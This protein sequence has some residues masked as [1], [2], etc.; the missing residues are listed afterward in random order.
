MDLDGQGYAGREEF[1]ARLRE[2]YSLTPTAMR[3]VETLFFDHVWCQPVVVAGVPEFM[4]A[5]VAH[6]F[7]LGI[8]T[9]GS[10]EAQ[11]VKL[12]YSGVDRLADAVVISTEVGV[13]KPDPAIF[14]A[15]IGQLHIVPQ[16][17]WFVGDNP[18]NDIWG[19]KQVGFGTGWVHRD[20]EWPDAG[21]TGINSGGW[22]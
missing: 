11:S 7:R 18:M 14:Q 19:A 3:A 22:I 17:R 10:V 20:L 6:G 4:Q 5:I 16:S 13:K 8:V 15:V 21:P 9:N 12:K 2:E 1:F